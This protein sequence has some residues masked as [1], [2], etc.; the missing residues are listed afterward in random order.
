[1]G[2]ILPTIN[3][4]DDIKALSWDDLDDL[5][6]EIREEITAVVSRNGGHLSSN[7]GVVELTLALHKCYDFRKDRLVFDVGHQ[8][9]THKILT[10]RREAF[11]TIRTAG[12][13]SGFPNPAESP[14]DTFIEGH[15]GAALSQA[16]GLVLGRE[17]KSVPGRV[18]AVVGDGSLTAGMALEALNN[19]GHMGKR[20]L[21][22]LNDNNMSISRSVGGISNY[23]NSIRVGPTYNEL[24]QEVRSLLRR[25]PKLGPTMEAAIADI[26][27]G[28]RRA[29]MPGRMFEE[30][31]FAYF[32][33]FDGHNIK[34]LCETFT[35]IEQLPLDKPVMVHVLTEKG[36]GFAPAEEDPTR[37]HSA[38]PFT[39]GNGKVKAASE[40]PRIPTYT[41][42]FADALVDVGRRNEN[43]VVITAA[44]PDGTGTIAFGRQ[45]PERFFDVG[46]CE[47]HAVGLAAGL[48]TAGLV[49]VVAV[50]STFLQRAYDQLF[51]EIT[52]QGLSCVF[53]LDRA[54][55]V[56]ADG[57]THHG[58]FDIGYTRQFP[59]MVVMAPA[60][61]AELKMMLDFAVGLGRPVA[62]RFPRATIVESL[63]GV[64]PIAI[65][66]GRATQ[67]VPGGDATI[68]AY[69][70]TVA[71]ALD[72]TKVLQA[73]GINAALVNAR[74]A[75]PLDEELILEA[76]R[77]GPI[78]TVE[79]HAAVG[80]FGAAVLEVLADR[81]AAARVVRLAVPDRFIVHGVRARLLASLSLDAA[82]IADAV[83]DALETRGLSQAHPAAGEAVR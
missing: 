8:D 36:R 41:N 13:L 4:P 33:P 75:K 35:E 67:L 11:T 16:L 26:R 32:G 69:G 1:M 80:G 18:V 17:L 79:E 28:V 70:A 77:K 37:Y 52:L 3:C 82:G 2:R 44:M 40:G 54:G 57:P 47:Q 71:A 61:A 39:W 74:F 65:E 49:P 34:L 9:Y 64:E 42:V 27:D 6:V 22:V 24:K 73:E 55:L 59:G 23:L 7:L 62:M 60:D 46:I 10:G 19:A 66:L 14:W 30:M 31:G 56:G 76:A 25:I 53:C 72:A 51:H 45:F 81:H 68:L 58:V 43:V 83:R 78:V 15:A 48:A 63:A 38:A 12:G 21:V 29:V 50:Y 5:A 20:F